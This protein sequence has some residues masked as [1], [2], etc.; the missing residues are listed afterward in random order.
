MSNYDFTKYRYLAR[1]AKKNNIEQ[2]FRQPNVVGMAFG[3]RTV[4]DTIT[5]EPAVVIYVMKKVA[6]NVLPPSHLLPRKI[7]IGGDFINVDVVETG[8]LYAQSFTG[9][10]RPAPSGISCSQFD[11]GGAG[12]LGCLVKDLSDGSLCILSNNHVLAKENAAAIGDNILQPGT[13]PDS[14]SDPADAIATLKRFVTINPTGNTVDC[15]IAQVTNPGDVIDQMKNTLMDIV[16]PN[17]PAVGLLFAGGG[18]RTILNPI[19][20]VLKN[21]GI[22]FTHGPGATAPVEVG[23]NVEKVGR[24]TEYTTSTVTEIDVT[25]TIGYDFGNATF[26]HQIATAWLSCPGDS[27]SIVCR[28]GKGGTEEGDCP[29]CGS[30]QAAQA[31]LQRNLKKDVSAEKLF[32]DKYLSNTKTGRYL[33]DTFFANEDYIVKRANAANPAKEDISYVQYLYDKYAELFRDMVIH[34]G[35]GKH[36]VTKEHIEDAKQAL[37]RVERYLQKDEIEA[38]RQLFELAQAFEGKAMPEILKML[39]DKEVYNKVVRIVSGVDGLKRK[40]C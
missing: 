32:R 19:N 13:G 18:N 25:V 17:H 6:K 14:G 37:G 16:N 26:D 7:Y 22:E 1:T 30:T 40:C 3:R 20:E 23:T 31:L 28:G 9:R 24:T 8:P 12:T 38:S 27:G 29:S 5:D 33:L 15:A 2:Y 21:L 39:D 11:L 36:V 10:E 35:D 34:A 4:G